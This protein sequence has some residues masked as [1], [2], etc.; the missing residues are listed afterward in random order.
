MTT[1]DI[2][3]TV[4]EGGSFVLSDIEEKLEASYIEGKITFAEKIELSSSINT[5]AFTLILYNIFNIGQKSKLFFWRKVLYL[6]L[7]LPHCHR[8]HIRT[9]AFPLQHTLALLARFVLIWAKKPL[10]QFTKSKSQ[11]QALGQ[12]QRHQPL[13]RPHGQSRKV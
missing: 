2:Y 10:P 13:N 7:H 12:W 8:L 11:K 6:L 1:Y 5:F 4:I 9:S 3:K